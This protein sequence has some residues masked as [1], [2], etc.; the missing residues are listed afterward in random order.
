MSPMTWRD[1]LKGDVFPWLLESDSPCVRYMTLRDLLDRPEHD[2][3]LQAAKKA[4]HRQGVIALVLAKMN[5]EGYWVKSGGGYNPKYKASVWSLILLAQLGASVDQDAR[6]QKACVYY[7]D[8]AMTGNGQFSLNEVPSGTVD[9]LQGNMCWSMLELG[10]D[11]P[12]LAKAF[13]WMARSL[14]GEGVASMQERQAPL[15]YYAGKC[16]PNFACG[17]NN[18]LACAWGGTKVMLAFSKLPEERRTPL[19]KRAIQQGLDFFFSTDPSQ[20]NYPNGWAE[21]PSGNWWKFGFPVFYVTDILQIAE[22]LTGLGY[23]RDRRLTKTLQLIREKQDN[24]GRWPLE[25]DY[26]GKTWG[27][28]G[29]KKEPNKWVT[30]RA[31]R[32][33]KAAA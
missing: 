9:C 32:V 3:E 5:P 14:T 13:E 27:N 18:K 29:V 2:P 33:L 16:G 12:R 28:F 21:K 7:L 25:Y 15:R 11:D 23:G 20:A 1:P 19:I 6:L 24:K 22:A 17:A 26:E 31:L 4:A 8:H 10:M 30:L